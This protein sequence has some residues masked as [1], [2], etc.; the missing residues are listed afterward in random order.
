M[1]VVL[2]VKLFLNWLKKMN[3]IQVKKNYL[4]VQSVLNVGGLSVKKYSS[5]RRSTLKLLRTAWYMTHSGKL[6]TGLRETFDGWKTRCNRRLSSISS[7]PITDKKYDSR[8]CS[9]CLRKTK[10]KE[11]SSV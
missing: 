8:K 2:F 3:F 7:T 1:N 4:L 5:E 11:G 9:T 6:H 10:V